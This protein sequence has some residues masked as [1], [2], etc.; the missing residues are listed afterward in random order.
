MTAEWE[1]DVHTLGTIWRGPS[2]DELASLLNAAA[3]EGWETV[4][5]TSPSNGNRWFIVL[6][7]SLAKKVRKRRDPWP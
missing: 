6:R 3:A 4:S 5:V 7:R 1:Y 2:P